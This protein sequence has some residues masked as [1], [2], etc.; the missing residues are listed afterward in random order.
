MSCFV[1]SEKLI[2]RVAVLVCDVI[3]NPGHT[4]DLRY[5]LHDALKRANRETIQDYAEALHELPVD[6]PTYTLSYADMAAILTA[7][8]YEAYYKRY[9]QEAQPIDADFWADYYKPMTF[10]RIHWLSM[11]ADELTGLIKSLECYM[12]QCCE[13]GG[14]PQFLHVLKAMKQEMYRQCVQKFVPGYNN[15]KW[16]E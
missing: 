15:A 6:D 3:Q 8:N 14:V 13:Y 16:G 11:T 9:P 5:H 2:A 1:C 4:V 7:L 12:Y 10:P